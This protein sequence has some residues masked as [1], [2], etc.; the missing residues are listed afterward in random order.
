MYMVLQYL[1]EKLKKKRRHGRQGLSPTDEIEGVKRVRV[2]ASCTA[3]PNLTA[4]VPT[5]VHW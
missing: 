3:V 4:V 1:P 2:V 5:Y